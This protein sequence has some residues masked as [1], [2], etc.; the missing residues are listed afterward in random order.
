MESFVNKLAKGIQ[1]TYH[2]RL[3]ILAYHG[4]VKNTPDLYEVRADI[5]SDQMLILKDEG[6]HVLHLRQ[7]VKNLYNGQIAGKTVVITFDDAHESI[8]ENAVPV[9]QKFGFP[10]TIFVP[11][12][13]AGE[14]EHFSKDDEIGN[15]IMD[16]SQ[17]KSLVDVGICVDSHSVSHPDLRT[18]NQKALNYEIQESYISLVNQFGKR[19]YFFAYPFGL[20]DRNIRNSI[21]ESK[22]VGALCYGSI[23]SNWQKTDIYQL[24]REKI[25]STINLKQFKKIINPDYDIKR[26]A[27]AYIKKSFRLHCI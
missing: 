22:F 11:T 16:W 3:K 1:S 24:K 15:R 26:S 21:A 12:G 19:D 10:A 27:I 9:L 7:A 13:L 6:Y 2:Q 25:L 20:F 23:L 17:L 18:L 8:L 4:V 14:K 5:F